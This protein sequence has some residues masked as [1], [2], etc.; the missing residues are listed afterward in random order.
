MLS[1]TV[2]G[3]E[4]THGNETSPQ[5]GYFT[6]PHKISLTMHSLELSYSREFLAQKRISF[7]TTLGAGVILGKSAQSQIDNL[8]DYETEVSNGFVTSAALSLNLNFRYYKL[9][10]QPFIG[11]SYRKHQLDF[12]TSYTTSNTD[13]LVSITYD[14]ELENKVIQLGCRFLNKRKNLMSSFSVNYLN[15]ETTAK[16]L[17]SAALNDSSISISNPN[18]DQSPLE[19]KPLSFSIGAGYLF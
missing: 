16:D 13:S 1:N 18:L 5:S 4:F 9:R 7:N 10:I 2:G 15:A 17:Q 3:M 6:L 11:F 8:Y 14:T 12:Q 19:Q